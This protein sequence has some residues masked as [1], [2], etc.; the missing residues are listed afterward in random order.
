MAYSVGSSGSGPAA[1]LFG[2]DDEF[3]RSIGDPMLLELL[4][5][6]S[7]TF[8]EF[9]KHRQI[10]DTVTPRQFQEAGVQ[11]LCITLP[12]VHQLR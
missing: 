5:K 7:D 12:L 9:D 3:A 11:L 2:L 4:T 1:A 6:W 10:L 8:V